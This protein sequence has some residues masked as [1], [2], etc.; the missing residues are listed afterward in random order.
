[1]RLASPEALLFVAPM[2]AVLVYL[3]ARTRRTLAP[4]RRRLY[5]A[6]AGLAGLAA[7]LAALGLE[8]AYTR[9][10]TT[11]VL[12]V[13]RSRS[14]ATGDA[15]IEARLGEAQRAL[16]AMRPDDR[17]GLVVVGT[18]AETVLAPSPRALLPRAQADVPREAS[19]L[20][21]GIRH[22]LADIPEA[23]AARIVLLSDG[24][25][26]TGDAVNAASAASSRGVSVDVVPIERAPSPELAV[27][28]VRAPAH[29]T[30]DEPIALRVVTRATRAARVRLRLRRDGTVIAVGE[31]RVGAGHDALVVRDVPDA[32]G[33][34]RYDVELEPLEAGTDTSTANDRG[35]AFV[36][37]E[38][39]ARALLVA[40]DEADVAPLA[41][42][43]QAMGALPVVVPPT[44]LPHT[45]PE[46]AA[47]DLVALVDVPAT[48]LTE[49]QVENLAGYVRDLGGGFLMAGARRSFGLGGYSGTPIEEVM[50]VT[51]DLRRRRDR[52]SLSLAISIDR[53]GSMTAPVDPTRTKMDLANEAAARSALLLSPTDRVAIAHVDTEVHWTQPM[54][55]VESPGRIAAAARHATPGGG[56]IYVDVA[57][58]EAYAALRREPSQ[59]LH[60]ILFSDGSDSEQIEGCRERVARA[61]GQKITTTV[62]SMGNGPDT[63][64]LEALA[65]IGHGR[66]YIVEDMT[67]LPRIFTQ[68]TMEASRAGIVE[69]TFRPTIVEPGPAVVG[70]DFAAA[71]HLHGLA[72]VE[73][74]AEATV[75]LRAGRTEPLLVRWQHG[76]GRSAVLTTDL[77][78]ELARDWLAWSGFRALLGQLSRD[79]A[80][81]ETPSDVDVR[82]ELEGGRG[83]IVAEAISGDGRFRNHLDLE[84]RVASPRGGTER[85]RLEQT[86]PGRYEATFD[87]SVPGP[88]LAT[89]RDDDV[90]L[91]GTVGAVRAVASELTGEGT[92][93]ARLAE[94]ASAGGGTTR[95]RL[96][97][98]FTL[99]GPP[100]EGFVPV[101]PELLA[102]AL[103]AFLVSVASRRLVLPHALLARLRVR[104][105]VHREASPQA[106][107]TLATA[108][109]ARKEKEKVY[110]PVPVVEAA[111]AAAPKEAAEAKHEPPLA[112]P[113][114]SLAERLLEQKRK[115]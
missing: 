83:R 19:D 11:V 4:S 41:A 69:K 21:A 37:V 63:P 104:R 91:V 77:G 92:D 17:V 10:A 52:L 94:I 102:F 68:E 45:M 73:A 93:H 22:A 99:R 55:L 20:E 35:S 50:P 40:E 26:T 81:R 71:P 29:V 38:G 64:E 107:E 65:R 6:S 72:L 47:Y 79:L 15:Q 33:I 14:T 2:L 44:A 43:V 18:E 67:Q 3:L 114:T 109:R 76:L 54:T 49:A 66:F 36:R 53:S 58:D 7:A 75:H 60:L 88:Y 8:I 96:D 89:V 27:L 51:F 74:R 105:I 87:A 9:D 48:A 95:R 57:L 56:G 90:G 103:V 34:H 24:L 78:G 112:A 80:R 23:S 82:V 62:V 46:L 70:L 98:L 85:V 113:K 5:L 25:E 110:E 111:P 1:M 28:S 31:A 16:G 115:R 84:A 106:V 12:V 61:Y 32:P 13:D 97:D 101:A 86:S 108:R 39:S 59:L 42:A 100:L 30:P